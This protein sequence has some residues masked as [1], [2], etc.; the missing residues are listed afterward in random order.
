M[1]SKSEYRKDQSPPNTPPPPRHIIVAEDDGYQVVQMQEQIARSNWNSWWSQGR[2]AAAAV[3]DDEEFVPSPGVAV[4]LAQSFI[5]VEQKVPDGELIRAV[6][7][8]LRQIIEMIAR[9]YDRVYSIDAR[10]WEKI[11]AA[12]YEASGLFDHVT[13][14]PRSGDDGR[15]VLAVKHGF[16]SLRVME[17]VKRHKPGHQV[18]A[19]DV[20]DLLG[21]LY[22]EPGVN[23]GVISTTWQFTP[24]IKDNPKIQQYVPDRLELLDGAALLRRMVECLNQMKGK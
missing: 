11:V 6:T 2:H 22:S 17:S 23:K 19:A 7:L 21:A 20:R 12:T 1:S 24:G 3:G 14:T 9:D 10:T 15:D 8:P 4:L 16:W 18:T 13:L 5:V